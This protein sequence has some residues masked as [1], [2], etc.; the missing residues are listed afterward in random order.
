MGFVLR[1]WKPTQEKP[2]F[3]FKMHWS[4]QKSTKNIWA[5]QL[6]V[7]VVGKERGTYSILKLGK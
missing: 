4:E 5:I 6:N 2:G 1:I 3:K 7:K